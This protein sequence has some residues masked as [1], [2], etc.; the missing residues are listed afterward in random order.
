MLARKSI[1]LLVIAFDHADELLQQTC[2]RYDCGDTGSNN[3]LI[4]GRLRGLQDLVVRREW[5]FGKTGVKFTW[6]S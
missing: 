4:R 1:D 6:F 3:G 5:Y 2:P